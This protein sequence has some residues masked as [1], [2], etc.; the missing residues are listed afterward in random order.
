MLLLSFN[1]GK[2]NYAIQTHIVLEVIPLI[3]IDHVPQADVS[4]RGIIHYRGQPIP[5]LDLSICFNQQPSKQRLSSRII[6]CQLKLQQTTLVLGLIA[7]HVTETL[8]C[9]ES[10]LQDNGISDQQNNALGQICRHQ[11]KSI[12]IINTEQ[13]LPESIQLQLVSAKQ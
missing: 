1:I 13:L 4:I 6:I 10:E 9:N 7:E 12:Q 2:E 8:Q 5:V 11:D 3:P